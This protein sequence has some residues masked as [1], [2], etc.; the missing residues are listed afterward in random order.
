MCILHANTFLEF[1]DKN[2]AQK[3]QSDHGSMAQET[4]SGCTNPAGANLPSNTTT[5]SL[6]TY[7]DVPSP[8]GCYTRL[9]TGFLLIEFTLGIMGNLIVF[10]VFE[11][12]LIANYFVA[13]TV[14]IVM[15]MPILTLIFVRVAR[16]VIFS[17]A[18]W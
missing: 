10:A 15:T 1:K 7:Y 12:N 5:T 11:S 16:V 13:K 9:I 8:A 14:S 17:A 2:N 4:P 6:D 3:P 18:G